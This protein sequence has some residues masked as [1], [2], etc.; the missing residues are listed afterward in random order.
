MCK[1]IASSLKPTDSMLLSADECD[2]TNADGGS[3]E[4]EEKL[5]VALAG[6]SEA[7]R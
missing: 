7:A 4:A 3:L 1:E 6:L 5:P 2:K